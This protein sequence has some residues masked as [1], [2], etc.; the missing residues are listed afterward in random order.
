MPSH[1][2]KQKKFMTVVCKS[3]KFAKKVG[4][5]QSV[6]CDFHNADKKNES[7]PITFKQFL[8]I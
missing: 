6:G 8:I 3:K 4:V 5:P 1:S 7:A 2:E